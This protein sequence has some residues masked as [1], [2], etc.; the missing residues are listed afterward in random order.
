MDGQTAVLT[1]TTLGNLTIRLDG[2]PVGKLASRK[3]EALLVYLA[4]QSQPQPRERIATLL[5][6]DRPQQRALGNLS[7]LLSS[8]RKQLSPFIVADRHTIGLNSGRS[9]IVDALEFATAISNLQSSISLSKIDA[10]VDLYQGDFLAGFH[11]RRAS[12]F[13]EWAMLERE[14]LRLLA[15]EGLKTAVSH[16]QAQQQGKRAITY[17]R[18][19]LAIEPLHEQ[20]HQ[21]LMRLLVQ[22]GQRTAALAQ[23]ETCRQLLADELAVE[24]LPE[25]TALFEQIRRGE[26]LPA[27]RLQP[28]A[29][30]HNIPAETTPFVGRASELNAIGEQLAQSDCR[31]LTLV[32]PGGIGKTRLALQVATRQLGRFRDGVWFVSLVEAD[33]VEGVIT[34]VLNVLDIP[35]SAAQPLEEQLLQAL[36]HKELLLVLDNIEQLVADHAIVDW[37]TTLLQQ[38]PSVKLL[39][40]SRERLNLQAEWLFKLGGFAELADGVAL[41]VQGAQRVANG[42]VVE[43]EA[44]ETAVRQICEQVGGMPL[45]IKLAAAWVP[46]LSLAEISTEISS[47]LDILFTGWRDVPPRQRSI[48]AVFE[49]SWR[50]LES[51]ERKIFCQLALFRGSFSVAAA[52]NVTNCSLP[53]LMGFVDKSLLQRGTEN[54]RFVLHELLR[55]Y[56]LQQLARD[57][58]LLATTKTAFITFFAKKLAVSTADFKS[59]RQQMILQE[60]APDD[61]NIRWAWQWA[62][63]AQQVN[64][65]GQMIGSVIEI[66]RLT[67]RYHVGAKQLQRLNDAFAAPQTPLTQRLCLQALLGR[68]GAALELGDF[69]AAEQ[70]IAVSQNLIELLDESTLD[71]RREKAILAACRGSYFLDAAGDFVGSLRSHQQRLTLWQSLDDRWEMAVAYGSMGSVKMDLGDL[72]AAR[73]ILVQSLTMQEAV[74]NSRGIALTTAR[75]GLIDLTEG[76]LEQGVERLGTAVSLFR[77]QNEQHLLA[78]VMLNLGLGHVLQGSFQT[79]HEVLAEAKQIFTSLGIFYDAGH[80]SVLLGFASLHQGAW[81][82][83]DE[84]QQAGLTLA[85]QS[86]YQR[87]IA[88]AALVEGM[89][90]LARQDFAAAKTIFLHS[91]AIYQAHYQLQEE[92]ALVHASLAY[93]GRATAEQSLILTH[94]TAAV[95]ISLAQDSFME[96]VL[97]LAVG[98][99]LLIDVGERPF[100]AR[101]YATLMTYDYFAKSAWFA[102]V[103]ADELVQAHLPTMEAF[104]SLREGI[105]KTAVFFQIS[106]ERDEQ[107]NKS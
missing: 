45:A 13:S 66:Y 70:L 80:V 23:Y 74:Q 65:L 39:L 25:T 24:P 95:Q 78:S 102:T 4:C 12:G 28:I 79:G 77:A 58:R 17:A 3:A 27:E 7:V 8:L 36:R 50:R 69:V 85:T 104:R 67:N 31:L 82:E 53:E 14:R 103:V 101:C 100:A 99:L 54:G 62:I 106:L 51:H 105:E 64:T 20:S 72:V 38:A 83:A 56:G 2:V 73:Q 59:P 97:T 11:I 47:N 68:A 35:L 91:L 46:M 81:T 86:D 42:F 18:R 48:R 93:V 98:A 44:E 60:L 90:A 107:G 9:I 63:G 22:Q 10:A 96:Q 76:A 94:F 33:E 30:P 71:I 40:T 34:A 88:A 1:I 16:N 21:N 32:G 37:A 41:F 61:E 84:W 55:Q 89:V 43:G 19:L 57:S 87:T 15:I 52:R 92:M 5:W 29:L 6:D 75:L 26:L 49:S